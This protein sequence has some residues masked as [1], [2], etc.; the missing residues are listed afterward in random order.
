MKKAFL[1]AVFTI[2]S[3][4]SYSQSYSRK[5]QLQ[6]KRMNGKDVLELQQK[7]LNLGFSETGEAD[8]WFG[9]KTEKA[10]KNYQKLYGFEQNGIFDGKIFDCMYNSGKL[11][12]HFDTA[13]K[14]I[15]SI[16]ESKLST[17][18]IDYRGHS[19]EGGILSALFYK[20]KPVFY[21]ANIYGETSQ[22]ECKLYEISEAEEIFIEEYTFYNGNFGI[23]GIK[24]VE[25]TVF[26][27]YNGVD[28][29][30]TNGEFKKDHIENRELLIDM[31]SAYWH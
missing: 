1:I 10:L 19:T 30:I 25:T 7:L 28:Y 6:T 11:N 9:E 16:D 14:K 8:G 3:V 13:V 31:R 15:N 29:K 26:Y 23:E 20:D 21:R 27:V 4:I 17:R 2:L 12:A 24:G 5:L 22:V 18:E